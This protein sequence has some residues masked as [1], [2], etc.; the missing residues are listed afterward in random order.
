MLFEYIQG[1]GIIHLKRSKG[2]SCVYMLSC[3]FVDANVLSNVGNYCSS[4]TAGATTTSLTTSSRGSSGLFLLLVVD[5]LDI[6][7]RNVLVLLK[8]KLLHLVADIALYDNL[9]ASTG[10]LCDGRS[11]RELLTEILG[12]LQRATSAHS[13]SSSGTR[14]L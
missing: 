13:P 2:T 7:L 14:G 8:Q 9:L 4:R 6:V 11:G 12:N 5:E 10:N 1:L 3:A